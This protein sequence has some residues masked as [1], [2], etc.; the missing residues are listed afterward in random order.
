MKVIMRIMDYNAIIDPSIRNKG[1][2]IKWKQM[3]GLGGMGE[4]VSIL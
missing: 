2:A 1:G 4:H 3:G